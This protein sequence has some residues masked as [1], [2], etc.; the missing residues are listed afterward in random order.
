LEAM[1]CLQA[2]SG[3]LQK[4]QTRTCTRSVNWMIFAVMLSP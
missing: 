3:F 1:N 4:E 2:A